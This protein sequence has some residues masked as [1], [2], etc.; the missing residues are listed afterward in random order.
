VAEIQADDDRCLRV[1]SWAR[2]FLAVFL[3]NGVLTRSP[4]RLPG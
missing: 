2:G 3:Q 1:G 4:C